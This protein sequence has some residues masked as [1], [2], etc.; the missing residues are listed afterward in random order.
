[1]VL[2]GLFIHDGHPAGDCLTNVGPSL[3][4]R[5]ALAHAAREGRH[6]GNVVARLILLY[7][8]PEFHGIPSLT[9]DGQIRHARVCAHLLSFAVA[10]IIAPALISKPV[11][12][13]VLPYPSLL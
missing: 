7:D 1:M 4:K 11:L 12:P 10:V 3:L 8:N 6:L 5:F 2:P 9:D 13:R